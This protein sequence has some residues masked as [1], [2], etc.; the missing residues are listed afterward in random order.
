MAARNAVTLRKVGLVSGP[1]LLEP[2]HHMTEDAI[3]EHHNGEPL[4]DPRRPS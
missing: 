3:P 1:A 2:T 4:T